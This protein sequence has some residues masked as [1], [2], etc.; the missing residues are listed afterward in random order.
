MDCD[1]LLTLSGTVQLS[2]NWGGDFPHLSDGRHGHTV[3]ATG[4]GLR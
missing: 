2:P 1:Y 4:L 3:P